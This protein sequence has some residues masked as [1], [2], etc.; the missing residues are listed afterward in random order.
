MKIGVQ[1]YLGGEAANPAFLSAIARAAEERGFHSL[2]LPEHVVM[3]PE[4]DSPYPYSADGRFPF[5]LEALPFEPFTG[6]AFAA[7]VTSRI[8]LG[9][10]ICILPQR[11]PVYTAKQA[12][13]V[14]VL[15]GGRLD[16][17]IGVGWLREEFE[18]LAQPFE[19]RGA[20]ARDY[21]GVMRTLWCD[22]VSEY[23]GEFYTLPPCY[24]S[25]KP[26]Q[27][28]HPPLYFGGESDAALRRVAALGQ[29]WF[30]AGTT[31]DALPQRM[32]RL[33]ELLADEGRGIGDIDVFVG[34][35]GGKADLEMAQ[36]FRD[37]GAE[38]VILGLAGRDLQRL[39]RRLDD[40]ATGLVAPA[41]GL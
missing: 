16:F 6:L 35:P 4:F 10:G 18:A 39:L 40:Y 7:A 33:S 22:K 21:V 28:P 32:S 15:S 26:V 3:P 30:A 13:D 14:D 8:R 25:P 37:A 29:G 5:D 1:V 38:Q 34:P 20:R 36:R 19:R 24:Q 2:W 41:E 17:G 9:T 23:R 11:H 27:K 31:A 12:A